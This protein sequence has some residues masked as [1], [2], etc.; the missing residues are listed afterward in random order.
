[1]T[2]TRGRQQI[3]VL[4]LE[5]S[6]GVSAGERLLGNCRS[7]LGISARTAGSAGVRKLASRLDRGLL[8]K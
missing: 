8:C 4:G 6:S 3:E 1:M 7:A 5:R 2:L